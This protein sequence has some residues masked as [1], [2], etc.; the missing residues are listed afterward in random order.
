MELT[1]DE[2]IAGVA[3]VNFIGQTTASTSNEAHRMSDVLG[4]EL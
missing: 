1:V 2:W 3:F 4:L